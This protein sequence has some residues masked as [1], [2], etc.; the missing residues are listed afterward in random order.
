MLVRLLYT[1]R[2]KDPLTPAAVDALLAQCR[3]SNPVLGI[4]GVLCFCGDVYMQVLEGGRAA[5]NELYN[6][7]SKDTRHTDVTILN[8]EEVTH[9]RYGSWT[10]GRVNLE[11][12]NPS[13]LLKYSERAELDPYTVSGL[14]SLALVE[15]LI[16]TASI[17][18]RE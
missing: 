2:S 7:I 8:Y 12:V 9:R 14:V 15:E 4:T 6:Q 11:K 5:V 16:S 18:G 17:A 10:M 13:L 1:S 3:S